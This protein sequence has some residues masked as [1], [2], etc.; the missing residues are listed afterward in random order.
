[1]KLF[2]H[3]KSAFPSISLLKVAGA[4]FVLFPFVS[5]CTSLTDQFA[6]TASIAKT[7]DEEDAKNNKK[8]KSGGVNDVIPVPDEDGVQASLG[9]QPSLEKKV[10]DGTQAQAANEDDASDNQ[11]KT[12]LS[13]FSNKKNRD[14]GDATAVITSEPSDS[15]NSNVSKQEK[16]QVKV[17]PANSGISTQ[18]NDKIE[19]E[20]PKSLFSMFSNK[21]NDEQQVSDA[22]GKNGNLD[23][24]TASATIN[25]KNLAVDKS[26]LGRADSQDKGAR[27][28]LFSG[29][30][31]SSLNGGETGATN[32]L[33]SIKPDRV[34]RSQYSVELPGV[35]PNGGIEIKH[36]TSL[37]DDTDIDANEV[38]AFPSIQM[39]SVGGMGRNLPNGLRLAHKAVDARCLKPQ[40]ISLL[41]T[42]ERNYN[43]PVYITSGYRNPIY[44]RKVNGANRSLHMSCAAADIIVPGVHKYEIAKFVRSLPGRGGVGTY[45]HQAI[46]VDIGPRR[47][48]NWSCSGKK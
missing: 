26:L 7:V 3:D 24:G 48:W 44:N 38:E 34:D 41:K 43:R 9:N 25:N 30:S 10:V 17:N 33:A 19:K 46:H 2:C 18:S 8:R 45:C 39:A 1:M 5:S 13:M 27:L 23:N 31:D 29:N 37:Y 42:I 22:S 40:L 35:R 16:A 36:R 28:R 11:P 47:D 14:D 4:L 6:D 15:K 20:Q 21:K 32:K 12:L